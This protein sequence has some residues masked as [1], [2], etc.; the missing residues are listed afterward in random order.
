MIAY[1]ALAA[2]LVL[3]AGLL[4]DRGFTPARVW[5]YTWAVAWVCQALLGSKFWLD[6][7]TAVFVGVCNFAFIAGALIASHPSDRKP[8]SVALDTARWDRLEESSNIRLLV[9]AACVLVGLIALNIGLKN[10][11]H[12][13]VASIF[14]NSFSEFSQLANETKI[15]MTQLGLYVR[16]SGLTVAT[17]LLSCAAVLSGIELALVRRKL[18]VDS[19]AQLLAAGVVAL[20][21]LMSAGTGVRSYALIALLLAGSAYL[22]MKACLTGADFRI[23]RRLFISGFA[24]VSM[25]A[26]WSVVIQSGRRRDYSFDRLGDT[27]DYL[28]TWVAGYMPALSQWISAGGLQGDL[29]SLDRF[30]GSHLLRGGL[31]P[32]G[33]ASGQG[34][35]EVVEVVAIGNGATSNAMTIF[36]VLLQDFG[37]PGT[38]IAT[39]VLGFIAQRVYSRVGKGSIVLVVPLAGFYAAI[40]FSVNYWFFGYGSR[41]VGVALAFA[42]VLLSVRFKSRGV[43]SGHP[44]RAKRDIAEVAGP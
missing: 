33:L 15:G 34:F 8:R 20:A 22:A 4:P 23:P 2:A 35:D 24:T 32:L 14:A 9:G 44:V 30:A 40:L 11:G 42:V 28:R 26:L 5:A 36:R 39:L 16:S 31:A 29:L 19:R 38:I 27:L 12:P 13:G 3:S 37:Y 18:L 7:Y 10:I 21:F 25:L 6:G 41:V 1:L 43:V 17:V